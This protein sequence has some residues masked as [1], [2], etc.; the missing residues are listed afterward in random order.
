M[1]EMA[2]PRRAPPAFVRRNRDIM[3][4]FMDWGAFV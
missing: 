2:M 4:D 1:G 3:K